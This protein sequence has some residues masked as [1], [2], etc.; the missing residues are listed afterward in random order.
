L[1][2]IFLKLTETE[3]EEEE[4]ILDVETQL[5]ASMGLPLA[6]VSS[7]DQRRAVSQACWWA[8]SSAPNLVL[9]CCSCHLNEL[10]K[11]TETLRA[12]FA[13]TFDYVTEKELKQEACHILGRK[14]W[15]G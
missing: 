2:C 9:P 11:S 8:F 10:L 5:M 1:I 15:R 13:A 3:D 7:S 4:E 14:T 6:F 12:I